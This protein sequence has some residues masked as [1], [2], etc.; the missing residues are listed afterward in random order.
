VTEQL[1]GAEILVRSLADEGVEY[2]FG[3]PGGA[4]LHIYDEIFKQDRVKHVLVRHEQGATHAADGYARASG[5]PG[6]VLVTSGPGA[7]NCV[8]GIATAYMDSIPLVVITGQVATALIGN[9]AFQEVDCI[10]ITRPCVKHNFLVERA[11]DLA[12]TIKKAFFIATT[13]RPGPVV[14]D[15]PKDVTANM[16]EYRY[17]ESVDIRSYRPTLKGHPGQIKRAGQLLLSAQKPMIYTGGGVIL[18][19][20]SEKLTRFARLLGYPVTNTL[21]GLGAY[22]GSDPQFVGMLGMHG[23][24]EANMA[25]HHCDVL[26]AIGARFD[27]R[28]TG[29][30]EKFC[31]EAKIIHIDIDPASISKNVRVDVP[32]VG[33]VNSVLEELIELIEA[34]GKSPVD[35]ASDPWWS[36]INE[37]RALDC[38]A[39][40]RKSALIKPQ[41]VIQ[42]LHQVTNGDAY[43]TSDVGQHQMWAA[44][45]YPFDKPRRWINSGGLGT[46]GFGLPAAMG[47]QFA[48]PEATVACVTGEA[49]FVMCVQ[50]LSTCLQ[51]GLPIKILSLN[52]RYMGMVRQWQEFFY[53]R[54]YSHSY[55]DALPDFVKMAEAFGHV[56]MRVEQP[57][58]V[59]SA[60]KEAFALKDRLVLMDFITDQ[61]ENVYPMIAAGKGQHEMHLA[62]RERELA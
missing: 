57:G 36:Q 18:D 32:I 15:V 42:T 3:Y 6:V 25:M 23:T 40:D 33:S 9:D 60:I 21:M 59:E 2:V 30:L 29:D 45:F 34:S 10:G 47:V 48:F 49:S 35:R 22:P 11:E 13:G 4:V 37:W 55:M 8:T 26:I 38:L 58:D 12:E 61:S 28:V 5:K 50:E 7:T 46:M 44:Q 41:S 24:Y 62:P 31:P 16:A 27:D 14:V 39:Y 56:G 17:P 19:N 20:G 53:D 52:N 54:R 1:R 43:V 51:Y